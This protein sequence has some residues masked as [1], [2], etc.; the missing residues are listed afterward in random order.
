MS[1]DLI[2]SGPFE[3]PFTLSPKKIKIID[4]PQIK[5]F[6]NKAETTH[7]HRKQGIYVFATR[8]GKG[9]QPIY[10][11]KSTKGF[12]TECFTP[13]KLAHYAVALSNGDKGSPVMFFI[14][15]PGNSNKVPTKAITEIEGL[16]IQ[17]AASK[18][19][20]LRNKIGTK[21]ADWSIKGVIRGGTGKKTK[22]A[23]SF[24]TM[25]GI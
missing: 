4:S 22:T 9:F 13:H 7:F 6:W 21:T 16:M 10:V 8:A 20:A 25:M 15:P 18:N 17:F 11:G 14:A 24:T 2:V 12:K 5:S 23:T 19:P 1:T 3:I